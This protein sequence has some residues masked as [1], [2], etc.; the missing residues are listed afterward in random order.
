MI[1]ER[2]KFWADEARWP[3]DGPQHVFLARAVLLV[4]AALYGEAWT[5]DEVTVPEPFGYD[6]QLGAARLLDAD[7]Q[8]Q[9]LHPWQR[10]QIYHLLREHWHDGELSPLAVGALGPNINLSAEVWAYGLAIARKLDE[11]HAPTRAR[12]V[13]V[14]KTISD[15]S[16][17][18]LLRSALWH[19]Q[20]AVMSL[21]DPSLWSIGEVGQ[22]FCWCQMSAVTPF[23][24]A[25]GG[26]Q[27]QHIFI[28]RSS[29]DSFLAALESSRAKSEDAVGEKEVRV[30]NISYDPTL[31]QEWAAGYFGRDDIKTLRRK[32]EEKVVMELAL[33][34]FPRL[35]RNSF[36]VDI[37]DRRPSDWK[38]RAKKGA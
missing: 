34:N 29:L 33:Q 26:D 30:E 36:R 2:K 37:W 4:G 17:Q 12:L 5:G 22:R 6:V 28:E 31:L 9:M 20:S 35:G 27:Y 11:H 19:P 15:A 25:V 38:R 18:G 16:S 8:A 32:P 10:V 3:K 7:D 21:I 14:E 23:H 13:D 1:D 24:P